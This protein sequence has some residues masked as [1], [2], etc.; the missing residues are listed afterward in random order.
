MQKNTLRV[1]N[2]EVSVSLFM[3]FYHGVLE[4][5]DKAFDCCTLCL[6]PSNIFLHENSSFIITAVLDRL[7]EFLL[8]LFA[9]T[10]GN[11]FGHVNCIQQ[12]FVENPMVKI[13]ITVDY[14]DGLGRINHDPRSCKLES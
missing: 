8:E 7:S 14:P 9:D 5:L 10:L 12:N 11:C 6:D 3:A 2:S 13:E 4:L 1:I